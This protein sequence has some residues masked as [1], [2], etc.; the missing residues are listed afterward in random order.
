MLFSIIVFN[1]SQ[2]ILSWDLE[3]LEKSNPYRK[4]LAIITGLSAFIGKYFQLM[5]ISLQKS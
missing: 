2:A 4:P 3:K 1:I 5:W